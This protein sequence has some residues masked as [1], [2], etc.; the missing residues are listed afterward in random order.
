MA[1]AQRQ[2]LAAAIVEQLQRVLVEKGDK[3]VP[4][5][6]LRAL[7]RLQEIPPAEQEAA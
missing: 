1:L 5:E 6:L 7:Q 3:A 4:E 2:G